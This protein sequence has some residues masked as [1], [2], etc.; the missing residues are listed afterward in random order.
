MNPQTEP[1]YR[2]CTWW[3]RIPLS[4][5]T[6]L[7]A[8]QVREIERNARLLGHDVT[9]ERVRNNSA[10][11]QP[12]TARPG[13]YLAVELESANIWRG[14]PV[15]DWRCAPVGYATRRQLRETG[16]APGGHEPAGAIRRGDR[17]FAWLYRIDLCVPKRK[18]TAAQLAA[19]SKATAARRT[20][21]DCRRDAGYVLPLVYGGRCIDC[22]E[23]KSSAKA[24]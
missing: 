7:T 20:C 3:G 2:V 13:T 1:L 18:P 22:Y 16:L 12:K 9:T 6:G 17:L 23:G 8:T 11:Q 21:C 14:L 5:S 19:I 10:A 4:E 15:W 24:A